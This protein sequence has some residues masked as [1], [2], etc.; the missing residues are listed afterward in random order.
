MAWADGNT[1]DD[2]ILTID[3]IDFKATARSVMLEAEDDAVD[4]SNYADPKGER[5]GATT[6]TGEFELELTYGAPEVAAGTTVDAGTWNTLHAMRK[7]RKTFVFAPADAA[8]SAANPIATFDAYVPTI[9]FLNS[10]VAAGEVM[11]DTITVRP[12]GDP[13]FNVGP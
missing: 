12:I 5:P 10:E 7:Q 2:P 11:R 9:S 6:W 3:G 1:S 8:A 4:K 13:V